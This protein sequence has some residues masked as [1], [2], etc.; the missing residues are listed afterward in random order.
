MIDTG[1]AKHRAEKWQSFLHSLKPNCKN[2]WKI[3]RYFKNS[4]VQMPPL[5]HLGTECY[6]AQDKAGILATHFQTT[7]SLTSP[8]TLTRHASIVENVVHKF[9]QRKGKN[10]VAKGRITRLEVETNI[11]KLKPKT[12]PGEDGISNILIRK[13]TLN[14]ITRLT[15][16]FNSIL[17]LGYFPTRWKEAHVLAIP[18]PHKPPQEPGSYRPISLLPTMRKLLEKSVAKRLSRYAGINNI[19]PNEQFAFRKRHCSTGSVNR[20]YHPWV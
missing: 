4:R 7:H 14:T 10:I 16:L 2:L 17:R 6:M 15:Y 8:Q 20:L 11:R 5:Q 3:T 18:K 12:A 19:I 9:S 13:F 1:L